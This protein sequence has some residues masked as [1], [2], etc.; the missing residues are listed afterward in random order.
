MKRA[1]ERLYLASRSQT[2]H[3][4]DSHSF[5]LSDFVKD[6]EGEQITA[7]LI[8]DEVVGFISLWAED[9]FVHHLYVD[10]KHHGQ[11]VGSLLLNH[12]KSQHTAFKL[13]CLVDNQYAVDYY[14]RNG[15]KIEQESSDEMGG[16]YLMSWAKNSE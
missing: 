13:K 14:L 16:Y 15:L 8:D 12:I 5:S 7:A 4:L 6:T 11:G 3:W 1:L 9:P 2:F 10:S